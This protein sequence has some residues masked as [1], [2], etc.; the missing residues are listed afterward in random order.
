MRRP[1][2]VEVSD[3]EWKVLENH[4]NKLPADKLVALR[5]ACENLTPTSQLKMLEKAAERAQAMW[6]AEEREAK[7]S[8]TKFAKRQGEEKTEDKL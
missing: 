6:E 7:K 1:R 4:L 5:R 3:A 2:N 8:P